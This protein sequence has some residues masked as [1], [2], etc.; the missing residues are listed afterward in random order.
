MAKEKRTKAPHHGLGGRKF[1]IL[2]DK[3]RERVQN[4][5]RIRKI[6]ENDSRSK[7][8]ERHNITGEPGNI[9]RNVEE[10]EKRRTPHHMVRA[11]A[12]FEKERQSKAEP[13]TYSLNSSN[14][15]QCTN[16]QVCDEEDYK[17][18]IGRSI[19]T[20]RRRANPIIVDGRRQRKIMRHACADFGHASVLWAIF[21][22][23]AGGN[24]IR[25]ASAISNGM[26]RGVEMHFGIV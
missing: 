21:E 9:F 14:F 3:E 4:I 10:E 19:Y 17:T 23:P 8:E 7:D 11:R 18:R 2:P 16:V 26:M 20:P 22:K 15:G 6:F 24:H 25:V 1:S 13:K 12:T 5:G